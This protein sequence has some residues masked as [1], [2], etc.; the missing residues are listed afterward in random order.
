MRE[1]SEREVEQ[2]AGG[3]S[4]YQGASAIGTVMTVGAA[5]S[6]IGPAVWGLG[7][8]AM[9]GLAISQWWAN[10]VPMDHH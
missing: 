7:L 6:P 9:A 2:V 5:L 8:G 10:H 1:L 3:L 4:G